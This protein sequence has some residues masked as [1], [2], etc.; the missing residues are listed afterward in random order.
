MAA[1]MQEVA[2]ILRAGTLY[3][4]AFPMTIVRKLGI[5]RMNIPVKMVS[6]REA[7]VRRV[8]PNPRNRERRSM[9]MRR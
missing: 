2:A 6:A 1:P 9:E 3:I 4:R 8:I 5:V 7:D